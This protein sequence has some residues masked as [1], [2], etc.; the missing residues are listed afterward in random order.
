MA[1]GACV[2]QR[3]DGVRGRR[4]VGISEDDQQPGRTDPDQR[5]CRV[6]D[7][8]ES[9]LATD[10]RL[11]QVAAPFRQQMLQG[12][13]GDLSREG[14][15]L[16]A[17]HPEFGL[18]QLVQAG[19]LLHPVRRADRPADAVDDGQ[20]PDVVR[21]A[22]VGDG[23]RAAGVVADHS[24]DRRSVL[25][26]RVRTEP[27]TERGD[28][29]LEGGQDG[30]GFN[31]CG[32]ARG[33]HLQHLVEVPREVDHD[34]GPDGV[35]R[36]RRSAAPARHRDPGLPAHREDGQHIVGIDRLDD[37]RWQHAIVAG[38]GG[39]LGSPSESVGNLPAHRTAQLCGD[40]HRDVSPGRQRSG[41]RIS[42]PGRAGFP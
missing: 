32:A 5:H 41:H 13:P 30:P 17:D 31:Q 42:N 20:R 27:E 21:G 1:C 24:A 23:V 3:R 22:A 39:V 2:K 15:E 16:G 28:R 19:D 10:Q 40:T 12:V 8:P 7:H 11:R 29:R 35:T 26:R 37:N 14:A 18:D 38:V 33:V 36:D 25:R 4:H 9:A 6:G 34:A